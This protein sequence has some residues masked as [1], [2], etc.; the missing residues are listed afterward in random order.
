MLKTVK[1]LANGGLDLH[2]GVKHD[3]GAFG[4]TQS[5]RQDE[6]EGSTPGFVEDPTLQAGTQYKELGFRKG[7][8]Q[9]EQKPVIKSSW[10]IKT[11]F[12]KDQRAGERTNLQEMVPIAR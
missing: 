4:V 1:D 3:Q 7:A 11:L 12:I 9:S 10:I 2:I 5:N 8:L 6:F